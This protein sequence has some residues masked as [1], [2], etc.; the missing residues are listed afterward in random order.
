MDKKPECP[1]CSPSISEAVFLESDNFLAIYNNAPI[2][3]GHSLI[4][5]KNHIISFLE[6]NETE[7]SEL[8]CLGQKAARLLLNYFSNTGFNLSIQDGFWAGQ[9]VFHLHMHIIPRK[10]GDLHEPGDW[11]PKLEKEF[12][13]ENIDSNARPKLRKEELQKIVTFLKKGK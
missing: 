2:L 9:T 12:Y 4:I 5:P 3:P 8:I 10:Q 6:L 13:S 7:L 1:F 11:Y